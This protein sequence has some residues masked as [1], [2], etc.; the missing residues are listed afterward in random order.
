MVKIS[1]I[2]KEDVATASPDATIQNIARI[3]SNNKFGSV[4]IT[5]FD[6]D[7]P[8]GIIT[9]SRIVDLVAQG[10]D[11]NKALVK[12]VMT[13]KLVTAEPTESIEVVAKRMSKNNIDRMPIV[14]RGKLVGIISYKDILATTP[15]M[16]EILSEKLKATSMRPPGRNQSI[17]GL[18]E[19]CGTYSDKLRD[20]GQGWFCEE[21]R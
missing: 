11:P 3:M 14:E 21:C 5:D 1:E 12:T 6:S 19:N 20:L 17:S 4:V 8:L 16:I 9:W 7:K 18:C 2:M 13:K 15:E 10:K